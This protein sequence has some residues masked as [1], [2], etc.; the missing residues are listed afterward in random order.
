[1]RRS[2]YCSV[3]AAART[4]Y[5]SSEGALVI[6]VHR[7]VLVWLPRSIIS[8]ACLFAHSAIRSVCVLSVSPCLSTA[9]FVYSVPICACSLAH[10]V[11]SC[12]L[13]WLLISI[14][15]V[16]SPNVDTLAKCGQFASVTSGPRQ[17]QY[18]IYT[19]KRWL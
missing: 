4:A 2:G 10:F 17:S 6:R 15:I 13:R 19:C 12:L 9:T 7:M 1:M 5:Q 16:P 18:S 3:G 14:L 11:S 8:V